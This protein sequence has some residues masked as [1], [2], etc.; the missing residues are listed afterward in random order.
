MIDLK[1]HVPSFISELEEMKLLYEIEN[2]DINELFNAIQQVKDDMFIT[3]ATDEAIVR[4]EDFLSLKGQGSLS[5][6]KSYLISLMQGKKL[7]KRTI[8]N[9][10]NTIAG[11]KCIVKFYGADE[12]DNPEPGHGVIEIKVLNPD[13]DKDY[14]FDDIQRTLRL[15]VPAHLKI[16]IMKYFGT[17]SYIKDNFT[18]WSAVS[19]FDWSSVQIKYWDDLKQYTWDDINKLALN[20]DSLNPSNNWQAIRDYIPAE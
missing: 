13:Y 8:E 17:W 15:I 14:K 7:N 2:V 20:W 5:Q 16:F 4:L 11:A 19:T 10:V 3:T 12:T 18:D 1:K 9:I 6:R